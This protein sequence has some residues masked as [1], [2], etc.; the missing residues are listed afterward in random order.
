MSLPNDARTRGIGYGLLTGVVALCA[1]GL[2]VFA[3]Q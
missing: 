1:A 2:A 3:F